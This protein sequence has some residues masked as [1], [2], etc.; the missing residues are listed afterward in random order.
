M[1]T[2]H[3]GTHSVTCHQAEETF[4]PLPQLKLGEKYMP[5]Q[6]HSTKC[7]RF[8]ENNLL[9]YRDSTENSGMFSLSQMC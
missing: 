9:R 6:M 5:Y 1:S 7:H 3:M 2:S 8:R 4:S